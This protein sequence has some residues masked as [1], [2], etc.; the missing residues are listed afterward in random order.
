MER[1]QPL[2][3]TRRHD[4][5]LG[6]PVGWAAARRRPAQYFERRR[7]RVSPAQ[8]RPVHGQEKRFIRDIRAFG[9]EIWSARGRERCQ[10]RV[11]GVAARRSAAMG[12]CPSISVR[13]TASDSMGRKD[14]AARGIPALGVAPHGVVIVP[15]LPWATAVPML[16]EWTSSPMSGTAC[17]IMWLPGLD[18]LIGNTARAVTPHRGTIWPQTILADTHLQP[19][20]ICM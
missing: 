19:R 2:C 6:K 17:F 9:C 13:R 14:A 11:S 7:R 3:Q 5:I 12:R 20:Q 4:S 8:E 15:S 1:R 10:P 18:L 16:W